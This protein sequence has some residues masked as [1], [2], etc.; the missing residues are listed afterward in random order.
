MDYTRREFAAIVGLVGLGGCARLE[1][2]RLGAITPDFD[3]GQDGPLR[4]AVLVGPRLVDARSTGIVGRAVNAINND[5]SIGLVIVVGNITGN[6]YLGEM[7]LARIALDRLRVEY[8][9]VPGP[10]DYSDATGEGYESFRRYFKQPRWRENRSGWAIVGL[11]SSD[12]P[13]DDAASWLEEEIAQI[14]PARPVALFCYRPDSGKD[15]EEWVGPLSRYQGGNLRLV[16]SGDYRGNRVEERG[17]TRIVSTAC[18]STTQ[19]NSDASAAKGFQVITLDG[20]SVQ[21]EFVEV[22]A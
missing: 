9:C 13:G 16:L 14:D 22:P 19:E 15:G 8:H 3:F 10:T 21:H 2:S 11:D 12:R 4:I 20:E 1:Q 7:N 18:C 17:N 6:G 5:E